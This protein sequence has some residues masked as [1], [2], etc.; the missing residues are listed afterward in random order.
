MNHYLRITINR[1]QFVRVGCLA[2]AAALA[3]WPAAARAEDNGSVFNLEPSEKHP[4][5]SEGSF[6][7]LKSGRILFFYTQFYGGSGDENPARIVSICSDDGGRTWSGKPAVVVEN[8]TAANVMSVSVLR[9]Q[10]GAIGLFYLVKN[11]LLDCRP[12]MRV[13]RDEAETWSEA[14]QV[15]EAPGY[16]VLNND[17]IIQLKNGRLVAPVAFHR[18]RA[19]NPK[20]YHSLDSCGLALWYLS[21]DEGKTWQEA[22]TWWA[23]PARTHTGLQEPGVVELLDGRLFSWMRTDQGAQFGCYSTD[24]G[25]NWP[26]PER[27]TLQSPESPAS[28]KR[29]PGSADLLAIFNDHSGRFTFSKGKRTPL[30]AAISSDGGKSWPRCRLIE[31]NPDGCYCYAAIHFTADAVLLAYC[32]G[33]SK[34]GGLSRLRLRRMSLQWLKADGPSTA[35]VPSN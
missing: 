2:S 32:A 27:T 1:R 3:G 10:S 35:I 23:L 9:L 26:L 4:R 6:V 13:S 29:L 14:R 11:N 28:I 7:T 12:M 17:R 22:Q 31:E 19:S 15:G 18:A 24:G 20:S 21:D 8:G 34:V 16:F 33:D 5:N 30:V 25:Q